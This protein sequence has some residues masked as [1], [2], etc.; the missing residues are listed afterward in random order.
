[1]KTHKIVQESGGTRSR[2]K[3][4]NPR[5]KGKRGNP[6]PELV[7][8]PKSGRTRILVESKGMGSFLKA[9]LDEKGRV[10]GSNLRSGQDSCFKSGEVDAPGLIG[11]PDLK[12]VVH[13]RVPVPIVP[14]RRVALDPSNEGL[15]KLR[16]PD[17]HHMVLISEKAVPGSERGV[18]DGAKAPGEAKPIR[19]VKGV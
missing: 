1:M 16:L 8:H 12:E 7:S 10:F 15:A 13:K 17:V 18:N 4:D 14:N 9:F 2:V 6:S 11:S 3:R 19:H 5:G